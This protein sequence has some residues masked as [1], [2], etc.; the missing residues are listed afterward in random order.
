MRKVYIILVL[1]AT[2]LSFP[3]FLNAAIVGDLATTHR[4]TPLNG[5]VAWW[6]FDGQDMSATVARD[7]IGSYNGTLTRTK[8]VVGKVGQALQFD[9]AAATDIVTVGSMGTFPTRGTLSF[10]IYPD[11]VVNYRNI[12]HTET[13]NGCT[14]GAGNRGIRFEIYTT[15]SMG[16]LVGNDSATCAVNSNYGS[17]TFATDVKAKKWQHVTLVWDTVADTLVG[18]FDGAQVLNTA[19]TAWPAN[20]GNLHFGNGWDA[21][22]AERNWKGRLDDVRIYNR[23]LTA[24]EAYQLSRSGAEQVVGYSRQQTGA[25]PADYWSFNAGDM[26]SSTVLDRGSGLKNGTVRRITSAPCASTCTTTSISYPGAS[27]SGKIQQGLYFDNQ[28]YVDLGTTQI[29][30]GA[31]ALTIA[32]WIY[33]ELNT[34]GRTIFQR[35]SDAGATPRDIIVATSGGKLR[36]SLNGNSGSVPAWQTSAQVPLYGWHHVA[37]TFTASTA[38]KLYIDGVEQALDT[39]STV[40]ASINNNSTNTFIGATCAAQGNNGC[41]FNGTNPAAN[42]LWKGKIDEVRVYTRALSANEIYTMYRQGAAQF[43]SSTN[44]AASDAQLS[45]GLAGYWTFDGKDTSTTYVLDKSGNGN[46]GTLVNSPG[47]GVG[48]V[49]QAIDLSRAETQYVNVSDSTSLSIT[50]SITISAWVY[51]NSTTQFNSIVGKTN[52]SALPAPYD[53]YV[54]NTGKPSFLAGRG[55]SGS[56]TGYRGLE[57]TNSV[58]V[59]QWTHIAVT[60]PAMNS[61]I[62]TH[63][64][65]GKLNGSGTPCTVTISDN[66]TALYIGNR[67]ALDLNLDGKIDDVRI[68]DRALSANEIYQLYRLGAF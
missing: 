67:L 21:T 63:Y 62:I 23:A 26:A 66:N 4:S 43:T 41:P 8:R 24:A 47:P 49:G 7:R 39:T 1:V 51:L 52:I 25:G 13:S 30:G 9:G 38:V 18:Y 27:R 46:T 60:V 28:T 68:Y 32:A 48:K 55:V 2:S 42:E 14:S 33:P 40:P 20:I 15:K 19:H 6:T 34:G 5:L 16:L 65:N 44:L 61:G 37:F 22:I 36:I 58:P 29:G 31:T 50:S 3:S 10:W 45:K 12:L 11:E 57:A 17:Y 54:T 59:K 35:R 53:Y 56:C 64:L